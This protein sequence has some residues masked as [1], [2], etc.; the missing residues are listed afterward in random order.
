MVDDTFKIAVPPLTGTKKRDRKRQLILHCAATLFNT[1][2]PRATTLLDIT[3]Q[4]GLTKTSLYYYV[5]NK[6]DLIYQC[7]KESC[8][9]LSFIIEEA[10]AEHPD[11]FL[12]TLFGKFLDLWA[13]VLRVERPAFAILSEIQALKEPQ[14]S[15]LQAEYIALVLRVRDVLQQEIVG[16]RFRKTDPLAAAH[17]F[18]AT[19]QWSVVWLTRDHLEKLE[20]IKTA[21]QDIIRHGITNR[22]R[23]LSDFA[24][25]FVEKQDLEVFNR[26]MPV[27]K[28][29]A[30]F[31][32]E[33]SKQ[34]NKKGYHGTSIDSI[35]DELKVTK[36]AFY[37]HI[38]NKH[39]LLLRCFEHGIEQAEKSMAWAGKKGHDGLDKVCLA[40]G[41]I[42]AI[43][44]STRGPLINPGLL[45]VLDPEERQKMIAALRQISDDMGA[46]IRDGKADGSIRD[47]D[48]FLAESIL[49]GAVLAGD[50][51]CDWRPIENMLTDARQ[52]VRT[53]IIGTHP[54]I[55]LKAL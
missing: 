30:V 27:E 31:I 9:Q 3:S 16:G 54:E 5:A 37:Y 55:G 40:L 4:L 26:R 45:L 33:A 44:N 17:A 47:V 42:F 8:C 1:R 21:V 10:A 38:N 35:S 43:Q 39:E 25:E 2:G 22:A 41:Q 7:Y 52:Y 53:L 13:A 46:F 6:E 48:A 20:G 29:L 14:R 50:N 19:M 11:D 23:P 36:G 32:Q 24:F 49:S 51:L 34:F 28:K 12:A 15:E 18:F